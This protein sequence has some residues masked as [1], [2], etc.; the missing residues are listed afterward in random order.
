MKKLFSRIIL[1]IS[2]LFCIE[3]FSNEIIKNTDSSDASNVYPA[4][5][6]E[7]SADVQ[8]AKKQNKSAFKM[9][10]L[11]GK[12]QNAYSN[13]INGVKTKLN[14]K[15]QKTPDKANSEISDIETQE[16]QK[17]D[18]SV[19]NIIP[20]EEKK[21][22]SVLKN[23][24]SKVKN[25]QLPKLSNKNKKKRES[26][27]EFK[28]HS[29]TEVNESRNIKKIKEHINN[30]DYFKH[31]VKNKLYLDRFKTYGSSEDKSV[32]YEKK[33]IIEN[34]SGDLELNMENGIPIDVL[35]EQIEQTDPN[36]ADSKPI[37]LSV[38]ESIGIAL[39]KHPEILSAKLDTDIYRSIMVQTWSSYFP[40]L[41]A[42]FNIAHSN[43]KYHGMKYNYGYSSLYAPE[44]SAGMLLFDFGKTKTLSDMAKTSYDASRYNLQ[45]TIGY[46]IYSIKSSYYNVLFAQMQIDVYNKTIEDFDLQLQS[47]RKFFSIGKKPQIDVLTAESNLG[48]A[49]LNLV[50]AV[51][52]L[53]NAK[54]TFANNVGLP[55]F[56]NFELSDDL[57]YVEYNPDLEELLSNAFNIRPD[58]LSAEKEVESAYL[59][60]R[61]VKREF[62]PNLTANGSW[63]YS[64]V[65]DI[66]TSS[67]KVSLDLSYDSLNFMRLRKEYDIA[68]K[69]YEKALADYESKRQDIYL[70]VKQA[71][72]D[73]SNAKE[74]V[75]QADLNVQQA[76]AQHYHATGRYKAGYGDAI[77]IKDAENTYLNAQL[78]YYQALL[79]YTLTLAE[80]ER[81]VGKPVEPVNNNASAHNE[82]T[83]QNNTTETQE[84]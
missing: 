64:D 76:K 66:N 43:T 22:N 83:T 11:A 78:S 1:I 71:Y 60:M 52:T 65:D 28:K 23:I 29:L 61:K 19:V 81:V 53:E 32:F 13:S 27:L 36:D 49:K 21:K 59:A 57:N 72:I 58:L 34:E 48:N 7:N 51:N 35:I 33:N 69:S 4:A 37:K 82:E 9:K 3:G 14:S 25:V 80:L 74:G 79:D 46:I 45:D 8:T 40:T 17:T 30:E 10:N 12:M 16:L 20:K 44:L 18:E 31:D 73:Y 63:G 84:L 70:E 39:A 67:S 38:K 75:K 42:G 41:S 2:F 62:T 15:K 54:V 55:E 56:A 47:A 5:V 68:K 26:R 50:K 77:E 24:N 6:E